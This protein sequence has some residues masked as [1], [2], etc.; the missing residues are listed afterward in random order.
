MEVVFPEYRPYYGIGQYY[1]NWIFQPFLCNISKIF[2]I[3]CKRSHFSS[4]KLCESHLRLGKHVW[5]KWTIQHAFQTFRDSIDW[6]IS[7]LNTRA[8]SEANRI[9]KSTLHRREVWV[10]MNLTYFAIKLYLT[11]HICESCITKSIN[12]PTQN[13]PS[14]FLHRK[15]KLCWFLQHEMDTWKWSERCSASSLTS[16]H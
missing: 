12:S 14:S 10:A 13:S 1:R 8:L 7:D 11:P 6:P 3:L 4:V 5:Q 16:K 9:K 15:E 2:S